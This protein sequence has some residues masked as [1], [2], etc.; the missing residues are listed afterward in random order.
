MGALHKIQR[1]RSF[2]AGPSPSPDR[3]F[4]LA[5]ALAPAVTSSSLTPPKPKDSIH[6]ALHTYLFHKLFNKKMT[7]AVPAAPVVPRAT[8]LPTRGMAR[9]KNVL[10]GDTVILLGKAT[11][12]KSKP[13][14]VVFT[15][16]S[17]TSPRCVGQ[18]SCSYSDFLYS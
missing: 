5:L 9:V 14:E 10:S 8:V 18:F 11:T 1:T 15:L 16:G 2:V 6:T 3:F 13:P 7:T 4:F 12:P 17:I